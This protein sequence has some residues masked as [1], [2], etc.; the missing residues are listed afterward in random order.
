MYIIYQ[1]LIFVNIKY[2]SKEETPVKRG[3]MNFI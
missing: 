3:Y 2:F 1:L